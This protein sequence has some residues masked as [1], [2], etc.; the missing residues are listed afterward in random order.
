MKLTDADVLVPS[1]RAEAVRAFGDGAGVTVVAGGTIVMPELTLRRLRPERALLLARAGLD[2]IARENGTVRIGAAVPVARLVDEAPE[3]LATY[4]RYVGD[5]EIRGQATIGGNLC[6]APG[7]ESP[8]GDLQAPLLALGARVVSTGPGGERTDS[9]DDFLAGGGEGRLVLELEL[10]APASAGAASIRRPHAHSYSILSV[11]CATTADGTR[12][13]VAGAGP[14]AVRAPSVEGAL[15][16][17]ADAATAARRVLDDVEP[18]DDALAS[19]WYRK[20]MLPGLVARAL[21]QS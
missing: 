1:S 11:A 18:A 14:R 9:V 17:G 21:Q 12:V 16:E 3:P 8:R 19:A 15:A 5:Y 20:R 4:A 7:N 10:D 6:A 2:A 13:A